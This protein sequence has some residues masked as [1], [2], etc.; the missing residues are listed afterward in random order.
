MKLPDEFQDAHTT[1]MYM[2]DVMV[3]FLRSG[4]EQGAFNQ[5]FT[6][7][8]H[9]ISSL[10]NIDDQNILDW[11]EQNGKFA[12]RNL[13]IRTVVLPA[14]LSDMLH[15]F[16]EAL[17]SAKKGKMAVSFML[18]RKPIQESLYLLEAMAI[19]EVDFVQKLSEDP[20][21]LRP[22][23][24]GGPEGHTKRINKVLQKIGMAEL[25]SPEYLAE[26]RYQK[27]S[28]DSFDRICNQATHLF[29]EHK[30][31]KTELLNINF[32]FSGGSQI[33]SQQRYLYTRLP[34]VLYYTYFL[35]EYI[36]SRLCPS[37]PE[38]VENI[39]RRIMAYFLISYMQIE[40]DFLTDYMEELALGFCRKLCLDVSGELDVE[41]MVS[42]LEY[43]TETG[44]L[45]C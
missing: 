45:R 23:N 41:A 39:N 12:H 2:H 26:L 15:C 4:E 21:F 1:C 13:V 37:P 27:S 18:L 35:F 40:D 32:V 14:V 6:F 42:E 8:E 17:E 16:F 38:Y 30:A 43:I 29:T 22:K 36:A 3:E 25:L 24:G 7:E 28:F 10:E 11:L 44:E 19:S 9:E 34:Y 33:Y 20:M 5:K 31:I